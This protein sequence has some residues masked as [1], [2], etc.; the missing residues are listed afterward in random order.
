MVGEVSFERLSESIYAAVSGEHR[1]GTDA[2]LLADFSSPRRKDFVIDLCSGCGI[3]GLL[4]IRDFAPKRV[5]G[6]ELQKSAHE[7]AIMSKE[8]SGLSD[9]EPI[10]A[11]LREFTLEEKAD[12]ITC[13]PPYKSLGTGAKSRS[14]A[15]AIARHEQEC[16][17]FDVCEAARRNLRYGGR[18]C[19]C[20]RPERLGDCV[21]AMRR[22][23][24][25]PKRLRSVH[26]TFRDPA[27][28]I[29]LEGRLGGAPFL[30]IEPPLAVT[31]GSGGYSE[32]MK[33]IYRL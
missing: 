19:V 33:R 24:I 20:N 25:E 22:A 15:E 14:E 1:F 18:L 7:L 8:R 17:I 3:V 29:L 9:F 32:E 21:S 12:L 30:K 16:S 27:W 6:V 23:G 13:N 11:D 2:F 5:I 4:M 31:D 26:K 28:L 10:N